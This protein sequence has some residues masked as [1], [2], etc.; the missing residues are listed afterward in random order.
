MDRIFYNGDRSFIEGVHRSTHGRG[1][2]VILNSLS[3]EL[4][5]ASWD[6]LAKFG[7]FIEVGRR[8]AEWDVRMSMHPF[9]YNALLASADVMLL[10]EANVPLAWKILGAVTGLLAQGVIRHVEPLVVR[11]PS[12]IGN[13]LRLISAASHIGKVVVTYSPDDIVNVRPPLERHCMCSFRGDRSFILVGCLGGLGR[14]L[15]TWMVKNGARHLVFLNRSGD[16]KPEARQ[17]V[18]DLKEKGAN[19]VVLRGDVANRAQVST[20]VEQVK[21]ELP[22][23]GGVIQAAMVLNVCPVF[24]LSHTKSRFIK[25]I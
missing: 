10:P 22:P 20:L 12:E 23:I 11:P 3:E 18:K 4:L 6:C 21:R 17:L 2:D 15:V 14:S 25:A 16:S 7:R 9:R 1:V 13:L 8:N 19:V 24:S 5:Q